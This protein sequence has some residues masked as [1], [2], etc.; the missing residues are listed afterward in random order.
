M[1]NFNSEK[2]VS[3]LEERYLSK[4]NP[5]RALKMKAYMRNQFEYIGLSSPE[6]V[7]LSRS[8]LSANALPPDNMI[9]DVVELLWELPQREFQYFAIEL[10]RKRIKYMDKNFIRFL[11]ELIVRKS[12]WDTIDSIAANLVSAH[13]QRFPDLV[14]SVVSRWMDSG[15]IWLQR[16]CILFQLK[17][18]Q[19]TDLKLLYNLIDHLKESKEFFIQKAIGWILREYSKTNSDEIAE[20]VHNH[21]LKPLS[22]REALKIISKRK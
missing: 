10:M 22:K 20:Y 6:R 18:K 3:D 11:E 19:K 1:G 2:Y 17:Y 15:N 5:L 4:S 12:W 13:F 9:S 14:Q 7:D 8:F 21:E 16:S